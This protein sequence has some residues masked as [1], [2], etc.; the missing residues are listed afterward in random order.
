MGEEKNA[1]VFFKSFFLEV[2]LLED[3]IP[4]MD[5][6]RKAFQPVTVAATLL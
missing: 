6:A 1:Q 5:H 4:S 3:G 2:G